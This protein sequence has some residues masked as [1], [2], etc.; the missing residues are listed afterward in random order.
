MYW[1]L[2]P[3]F[4]FDKYDLFACLSIALIVCRLFV[5]GIFKCKTNLRYRPLLSL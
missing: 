2:L 1:N 5:E 3:C 4:Y